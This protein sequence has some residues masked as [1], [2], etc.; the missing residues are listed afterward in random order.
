LQ[1]S[2]AWDNQVVKILFCIVLYNLAEGRCKSVQIATLHK[3]RLTAKKDFGPA[4]VLKIKIRKIP[5]QQAVL[6]IRDVYPGSQILIF[7]QSGSRISDPDPK[8]ATT[9]RGE[10]KF[11]V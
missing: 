1:P 10:K 5:Q 2:K 11:I 8:T 4:A 6:R 7:T 3:K 9:E